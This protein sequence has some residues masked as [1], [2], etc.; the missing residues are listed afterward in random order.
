MVDTKFSLH[1]PKCGESVI[2]FSAD[3]DLN[4]PLTCGKCGAKTMIGEF[5]TASG[6][7][8]TDHLTDIARD[9][10]KGIKGFK[11]K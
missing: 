5:K 1:C 8:L 11:P 3:L 2:E 9:A 6:K 4:K 7:K 10:F